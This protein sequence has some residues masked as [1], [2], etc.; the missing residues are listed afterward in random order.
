MNNKNVISKIFVILGIILLGVPLLLPVI[1]GFISLS[2]YGMFRF[3]YLLP[4]EL[5]VVVLTGAVLVLIAAILARKHVKLIAWLFGGVVVTLG[6]LLIVPVATGINNS[7][8]GP[9]G[10]LLVILQI[11]VGLYWLAIIL[12]VGGGKLLLRDLFKKTE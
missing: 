10:I 9:T 7:M 6:A 12:L 2:R 5:F 8:E 11:I 3:D 1:I 4:A